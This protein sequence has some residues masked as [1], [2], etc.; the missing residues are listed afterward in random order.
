MSPPHQNP[1]SP[2]PWSQL[3][4]IPWLK[5]DR[6][7][8]GG[9]LLSAIGLLVSQP[10]AKPPQPAPDPNRFCQEVVQPEAVV[11]RDQLARLLTV[12]ERGERPKVREIVKEPYCRMPTLNIRAGA[13]TERDAYP[14]AFDPNTWLVVLYEEEA[15]VGY[16]FKRF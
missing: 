12:P 1:P 14:L 7:F 13:A 6:L 8:F 10:E 3:L 4:R 9:T 2:K 11:S 5:L 16:G 15:Y